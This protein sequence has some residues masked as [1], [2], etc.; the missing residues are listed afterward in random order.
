MSA[1]TTRQPNLPPPAAPDAVVY[2]AEYDDLGLDE[3]LDFAF[4]GN[5]I[6]DFYYRDGEENAVLFLTA[7]HDA[8][9]P[10]GILGVMDHVGE[11]GGNNAR[12]HRIDPDIA[13]GLLDK[14]GFVID[15]ESDLFAN[16]EDDHSLM[17]YDDAIYLR[18]DKFLFRAKKP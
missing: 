3:E 4:L 6:H 8:L 10:G 5:L 13:R 18:T 15:A 17:V 2:L 7:I 16:A 9:K 12:L 14:A 1:R 11:A